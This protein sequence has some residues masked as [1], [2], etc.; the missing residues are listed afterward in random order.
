MDASGIIAAL[1]RRFDNAREHAEG[2]KKIAPNS[3]GHGYDLGYSDAL[4]EF[5]ESLTDEELA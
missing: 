3:F 2:T 5:L 1:K 4:G